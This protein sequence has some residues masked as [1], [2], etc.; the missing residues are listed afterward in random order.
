MSEM[1]LIMKCRICGNETGNREY[2]AKEMMFGLRDK[3]HYFQCSECGCL[4]IHEFPAD[5]RKYY[6]NS[7]Y[8]Y[9]PSREPAVKRLL[10]RLRN[11]YALYG[12]SLIGKIL[13]W[14]YPTTQFEFLRPV[15]KELS[16]DSRILDV[17]CGAGKFLLT[18]HDLGFHNLSGIDP[19]I[20]Q[21][22]D[23][24]NGLIIRKQV[25][26][27]VEGRYDMVMFQHSFEHISDPMETLRSAFRLLIP[28]GCCV[29]RIPTVSSHAWKHYGVNWV[30]L[31]APRHFF[32]HSI[33]SMQ[34]LSDKAGFELCDVGYDSTDFQFW[35]SE[36]YIKDIPLEDEHSYTRN[37]QHS[38]FSKQEIASFKKQAAELNSAQQ[39]DQAIF[40][41]RK[42]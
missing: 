11:T 37:P 2:E 34:L 38:I 3:H 18:L 25:I 21:D 8:S 28:R 4:Q 5:M 12:R 27:E 35:G 30:Q 6:D 39:G 32:L 17:G 15:L 7:Y 9:K 41:L 13:C 29:I 20:E 19:F 26:H 40:Y 31:D 22:I 16:P 14:K 36:Q 23:Y 10:I 33:E 1:P 24:G 42:P